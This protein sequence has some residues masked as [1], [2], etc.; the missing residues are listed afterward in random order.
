MTHINK[1]K[2]KYTIDTITLIRKQHT[3]YDY[4]YMLCLIYSSGMGKL[5]Q[6]KIITVMV[7]NNSNIQS[8]IHSAL[9]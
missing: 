5:P 6:N 1:I 2:H 8:L 9:R 3:V 4:F 7:R